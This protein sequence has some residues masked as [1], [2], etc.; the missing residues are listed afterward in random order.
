MRDAGFE[1]RN[2]GIGLPNWSVRA[3][4]ARWLEAEGRAAAG[5]R[6]LDVGCGVKPYRPYFAGAAEYV[7]VD[8]AD[9]PH[10]DLQGSAEALPVEDGSYDI[11]LCLQVLEH[12]EDPLQVVRELHRVTRPGGRVLAATH[13][14]QVYHPLPEDHWRWTH[15]GLQRLFARGGDWRSVT[16]LPGA[17]TCACL[18]M[19]LATYIDLIAQRLHAVW[20]G[21]LVNAGVNRAAAAID[22]RS[23]LLREP[24][25]GSLHAN[26]HVTAER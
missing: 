23:L 15:T 9:N 25:P 19:L 13:G 4:M 8:V 14:T 10:A 20:A 18:G 6:V 22:A 17:G 5:K 11:V 21:K 3:P 26:F 2:P 7:G 1:H 16:V 24:V 12:V